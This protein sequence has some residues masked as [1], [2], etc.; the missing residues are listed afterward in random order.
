M[1]NFSL[2]LRFSI[3]AI[4]V[5]LG[6][7]LSI[8][9]FQRD[10]SLSDFRTEKRITRQVRSCAEQT[11]EMLEYLLHQGDIE[12]SNLVIS[13]FGDDSSL[14]LATLSDENNKIILTNHYKL[15]NQY[16]N[17]TRL[18]NYIS[19]IK[20]VQQQLSEQVIVTNNKKSI[21]AIYPVILNS[22][23]QKIPSGKVG[24][25]L[26][27]YDLSEYRHQAYMD[28]LERTVESAGVLALSCIAVWLFFDKTVTRRA[29]LLVEATNCLAKGNLSIRTKLQGADELAQI[30]VAFDDM[31]EQI[32]VNQRE[33]QDLVERRELINHL[34]IQIRDSLEL[35]KVLSTAVN[36]IRG[37]FNIDCCK[38]MWCSLTE[39]NYLKFELSH[40]AGL[41]ILN[42]NSN[43]EIDILGQKLL[44][45][46]LLRIDN[47][48]C[49]LQL[50]TTSRELLTSLGVASLL[51]TSLRTH[52]GKR[53]VIICEQYHECRRWTDGD[54]E[55]LQSVADQL[56]IAIDQAELYAHSQRATAIAESQA[57][58]LSQTIYELRQTQAQLIQTEKMSSLGQLVA[59]VAHEINNPVN[60]IFGNLLYAN[61]YFEDLLGLINLYQK[62]YPN[63]DPSIQNLTQEIT[64][65]YILE[66]LPKLLSSMQI[67]ADRIREIVLTLRNF[68]RLD[69][70]DMKP[71]NIHE[72]IDSTL[73]ILYNRLKGNSEHPPIQIIKHYGELPKVEC[74]AGQLNQVFMNIISNA[75]DALH[76]SAKKPFPEQITAEPLTITI[77][78]QLLEPDWVS[79]C[80]KDNGCGITETT[81]QKIFD[82]FFT[83]KP[84]GEGTGLGLSISYQIIVDKH[85]GYLKCV[86]APGQGAEFWIQIP[87]KQIELEPVPVL[88]VY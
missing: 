30:S 14:R 51:I 54:V 58:K 46:N 19:D 10:V 41:N 5:V 64:L 71:V 9:S 75:I 25:L 49:D 11:S 88:A 50:G 1:K 13:K 20:K 72:G 37:L 76:T 68:S 78:T 87:T 83:T 18:Q 70:A 32:Q 63:P 35:E 77:A 34:A 60:F 55:L 22:A 28:A 8:F 4:L 84:V 59:G 3:P 73:V 44:Y 52:S 36:E 62:H 29:I 24:I 23:S 79:I 16:L 12:G 2:P 7:L 82:P 42:N 86:S 81:R 6:T 21:L 27:E 61:N 15:R 40:Q 31:A 48:S 17:K 38:F 43:Q 26:L 66:D 33:L 56:A 45:A 80:I 67:G 74:Y 57:Q 69:E 85:G 39:D 47:A 53:G 65:D